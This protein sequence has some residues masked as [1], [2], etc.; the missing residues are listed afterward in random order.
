MSVIEET[1]PCRLDYTTKT[2]IKRQLKKEFSIE[3]IAGDAGSR[4]YF[5]ILGDNFSYILAKD[6]DIDQ[7]KQFIILT[8]ILHKNGICSPS[9]KAYNIDIGIII[10][11][12][13]GDNFLANVITEKNHIALYKKC[14]DFIFSMQNIV[15]KD[16]KLYDFAELYE[17]INL[18]NTWFLGEYCNYN[19]SNSEKDLLAKLECEICQQVSEIDKTFV[20][21]DYH[22]RNIAILRKDKVAII[23]FQDALIG[24]HCYDLV[25]ILRDYYRPLEKHNLRDLIN[26]YYKKATTNKIISCSESKFIETFQITALQ[27][28][29]KVLGIFCR[30]AIRDNKKNYLQYLPTVI[31]YIKDSTELLPKYRPILDIILQAWETR[32]KYD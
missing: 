25:S 3:S 32:D 26:Y 1:L 23:D 9:I 22:S 29:L 15:N 12:D 5:R 8:E 19:I 21:R 11:D 17:E 13:F 10:Q 14:I 20:H 18:A 31:R 16:I 7:V 6:S 27:R 28:H 30:L 2:W 24:P 4:N